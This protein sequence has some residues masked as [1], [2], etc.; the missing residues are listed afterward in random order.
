MER[1]Q[2]LLQSIALRFQLCNTLDVDKASRR[3]LSRFLHILTRMRRPADIALAVRADVMM[4][5]LCWN[6]NN[7]V[8]TSCC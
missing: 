7:A 4:L 5:H 1:L 8:I 3:R 6:E 2:V